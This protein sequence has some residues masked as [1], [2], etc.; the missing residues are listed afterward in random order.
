MTPRPSPHQKP[1]VKILNTTR[2]R[3]KNDTA[4]MI[5][6]R[7]S[8]HQLHVELRNMKRRCRKNTPTSNWKRG[9]I[10]CLNNRRWINTRKRGQLTGIW[11]HMKRGTEIKK[12]LG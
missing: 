11:S 2:I 12:P 5:S 7:T 8:G 10:S 3:L 1:R 9:A 4:A 6:D